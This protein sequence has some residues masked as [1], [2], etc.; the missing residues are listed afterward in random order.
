MEIQSAADREDSEVSNR[1]REDR[2]RRNQ[3]L[4]SEIGLQAGRARSAYVP[5][6]VTMFRCGI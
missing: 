1:C 6:C 3:H 2:V 4:D 5:G